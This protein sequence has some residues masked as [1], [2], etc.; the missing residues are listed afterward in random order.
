M[1]AQG[2]TPHAPPG[3]PPVWPPDPS[4]PPPM[5]EPP[6]PIPVAPAQTATPADGRSAGGGRGAKRR[7]KLLAAARYRVVNLSS[8]RLAAPWRDIAGNRDPWVV[9]RGCEGPRSVAKVASDPGAARALF[10]TRWQRRG[11]FLR[12]QRAWIGMQRPPRAPKRQAGVHCEVLLRARD[13]KG[14]AN[15]WTFR[16]VAD[17][18]GSATG[19][20]QVVSCCAHPPAKLTTAEVCHYVAVGARQEAGR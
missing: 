2:P 4:R 16:S 1:D 10:C 9:L 12:R 6:P 3:T 15:S 19:N 17:A 20:S 11:F 18:K 13:Q 8:R 5:T 14:R 7:D